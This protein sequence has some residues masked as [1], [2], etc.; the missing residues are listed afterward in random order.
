MD[1]T[2]QQDQE[3]LQEPVQDEQGIPATVALPEEDTAVQSDTGAVTANNKRKLKP[4]KSSGIALSFDTGLSG[5]L[6]DLSE[7]FKGWSV[8]RDP[9]RKKD[10]LKTAMDVLGSDVF[11]KPQTE[12]DEEA[13]IHQAIEKVKE[14]RNEL[15]DAQASQQILESNSTE[16]T[17]DAIEQLGKNKSKPVFVSELRAA[18]IRE[19][20]PT[21]SPGALY[22]A[23]A[24][25]T[26]MQ[27]AQRISLAQEDLWNSTGWF[28][29]VLDALEIVT[30]GLSL[31]FIASERASKAS[32]SLWSYVD[33][34][35][36]Y[37]DLAKRM[38]QVPIQERG[39]VV[40][41]L[42]AQYM[43]NE[44][45]FIGNS[46][47]LNQADQLELLERAFRD[48]FQAYLGGGAFDTGTII[49][50]ET[51]ERVFSAVDLL[52]LGLYGAGKKFGKAIFKKLT[53]NAGDRAFAG[54]RADTGSRADNLN[55]QDPVAFRVQ[56][57]KTESPILSLVEQGLPNF[58][59]ASRFLPVNDAI[60]I[61]IPVINYRG[62]NI[63]VQDAQRVLNQLD[64]RATGKLTRQARKNLD[65]ER[66]TI[67][68]RLAY[69]ESKAGLDEAA[70]PFLEQGLSRKNALRKGKQSQ[71]E[72]VQA[73]K[74]E[75]DYFNSVIR[76]SDQY[77]RAEAE[78]SR[79]RNLMDNGDVTFVSRKL[80][81]RIPLSPVKKIPSQ[82]N[83]IDDSVK[84]IEDVVKAEDELGIMNSFNRAVDEAPVGL[85]SANSQLEFTA[86]DPNRIS[87]SIRDIGQAS[88]IDPARY[89]AV[90]DDAAYTL[91]KS[92]GGTLKHVPGNTVW[93]ANNLS[94]SL[95]DFKVYFGNG[96]TGFETLEE[97][98]IA[99]KI[100]IG[101]DLK[102]VQINSRWYLEKEFT[103]KYNPEREAGYLDQS[104][105]SSMNPLT[106]WFINPLRKLSMANLRDVWANIEVNRSYASSV[107][108]PA[109][110]ALKSLSP[111]ELEDVSK[112]LSK[113]DEMQR[114]FQP[115]EMLE[116]LGHKISDRAY[117]AYIKTRAVFDMH[118]EVLNNS[119]RKVMERRGFKAMH[120]DD[121]KDSVFG[122]LIKKSEIEDDMRVLNMETGKP[123]NKAEIPE[124]YVV[125][126]SVHRKATDEDGDFTIVVGRQ[127]RI[128]ALP[129]RV[130][131]KRDGHVTRMYEDRQFKVVQKIKR[132]VNGKEVDDVRTLGI[133][134]LES[135]GGSLINALRKEAKYANSDLEVRRTVENPEQSVADFFEEMGTMGYSSS[136]ARAR[137]QQLFSA[138]MSPARIADPIESMAMAQYRIERELN[139]DVVKTLQQRF[140]NTFGDYLVDPTSPGK[141]IS[142]FPREPSFIKFRPDTPTSVRNQIENAYGYIYTMDGIRKGKIAEYFNSGMRAI[143]E[144]LYRAT[145][146]QLNK[147]LK[148]VMDGDVQRAFMRLATNAFIIGRPLYQIPT[149]LLQTLNIMMR[150]PSTGSWAAAKAIGVASALASRG[151]K[152]FAGMWKALGKT[153]YNDDQ[154]KQLLDLIDETGIVRTT[155]TVDDFLGNVSEGINRL[156]GPQ[157]FVSRAGGMAYDAA[158]YVPRKALGAS[159][160]LQEASLNYVN[161]VA[162]IAEF[163]SAIQRGAKLTA[164]SKS[165]I[166]IRARAL[167]QT[168]NSLDQFAYQ[169][170]HNPLQMLFQFVQHVHKLFLDIAVEPS[171]RATT[172]LL[173]GVF[174]KGGRGIVKGNEGVFAESR[175]VA[176]TMAGLTLAFFG[177]NGLP[178]GSDVGGKM[179]NGLREMYIT[180]YGNDLPDELWQLFQ[181]GLINML[182]NS[183]IDGN[184][185]VT[186]RIS[187]SA[188]SDTFAD[189]FDDFS[190]N[191][192]GAVGGLTR[193]VLDIGVAVKTLAKTP[194][195]STMEKGM[196]IVRETANFFS[197]MKDLERAQIASVWLTQPYNSTLSG[198]MRVTYDEAIFNAFSVNPKLVED[199]YR[200]AN[201]S[202]KKKTALE[203]RTNVM[204]R[205]MNRELTELQSAG[206]LDYIKTNQVMEKWV[207]RA[208]AHA[209]QGQYDE[210]RKQFKM[211]M[212]ESNGSGFQSFIRGYLDGQSTEQQI[213]S[214][215][216]LR[217]EVRFEEY[218]QQIDAQL[219]FLGDR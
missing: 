118:Y 109:Q 158:A 11:Q 14:Q 69:L 148:K 162:I 25:A 54:A 145:G 147:A 49:S 128:G 68:E 86:F 74:T 169:Q 40:D 23:D 13:L 114:V 48:G 9:I 124:D 170:G 157:G 52:T 7:N 98:S 212:I 127:E 134:R 149:N 151:S 180:A 89:G 96:D 153:G 142:G 182:I 201:F 156:K 66:K 90:L 92:T 8:T 205:Q 103:H 26:N 17:L 58:S 15:L 10:I 94:D 104:K 129:H 37:E 179:T 62:K 112:A 113:G 5:I 215:K 34:G 82:A 154:L 163:D 136:N 71:A 72:E 70:S 53:P 107:L 183:G 30:P 99:G 61:T 63:P 218:K 122:E 119:T 67:G 152:D 42:I 2:L 56:N 172:S 210:V 108:Q 75:R 123:I 111:K 206:K 1:D 194:D 102:P 16:E 36:A 155:G 165:D 138:D 208:K 73:L 204:I 38:Q 133:T 64:L 105:V 3:L 116:H 117:D 60:E 178:V 139:M 21:D 35:A 191:I 192:F 91:S 120:T 214:L 97:A 28:D 202:G 188:L 106:A 83:A 27:L 161:L 95:G 200:D 59:A 84:G 12:A 19:K 18:E 171:L 164:R 41:G 110:K 33:M 24:I 195:L 87:D 196:A 185:D 140:L 29:I 121:P 32:D 160:K 143:E 176:A 100:A 55:K 101:E 198:S 181:G 39:K 45:F 132:M 186:A 159:A 57:D 144:T 65:Q 126:R 167:T 146:R 135:E 115:E 93:R 189:M 211:F 78:A 6:L 193:S 88:L 216:R 81:S 177:V 85:D 31:N 209:E 47:A 207:T 150:Y 175:K 168:Q 43:A 217:N 141:K 213:R 219:F 80:A 46:N 125:I 190:L 79:L 130:V 131:N 51:G 77:A 20:Y 174:G 50:G 22:A 76:Q 137:G 203:E 166:L 197:G 44:T 4:T 187:P 199:L 184:V 173:P